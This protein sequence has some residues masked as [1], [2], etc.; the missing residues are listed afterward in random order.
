MLLILVLVVLEMVL[1]VVEPIH[2]VLGGGG[3]GRDLLV[4]NVIVLFVIIMDAFR[5]ICILF[6]LFIFV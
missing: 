5:V 1:R 6:F 3:L 2:N 4:L